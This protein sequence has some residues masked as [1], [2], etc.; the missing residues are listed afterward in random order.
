MDRQ[1]RGREVRARPAKL[2]GR[3]VVG[4]VGT[5]FPPPERGRK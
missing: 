4:M 2:S 1:T 5:I 3:R